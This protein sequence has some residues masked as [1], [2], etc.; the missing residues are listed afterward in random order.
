MDVMARVVLE[1][2][3]L[4]IAKLMENYF[5]FIRGRT[6]RYARVVRCCPSFPTSKTILKLVCDTE[7][8]RNLV[9]SEWNSRVS[10]SFFRTDGPRH[11]LR[12][13]FCILK[14]K[15]REREKS[16]DIEAKN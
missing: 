12:L 7:I 9:K 4:S 8:L 11:D 3:N 5:Y 14:K 1:P 10:K 13:L 6:I 15:K 16:D 2:V